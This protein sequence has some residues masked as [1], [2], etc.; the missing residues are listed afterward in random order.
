MEN[1]LTETSALYY[2]TERIPKTVLNSTGVQSW[3]HEDVLTREPISRFASAM[4]RDGAYLGAMPVNLFHF[5]KFDL[6]SITFNRIGYSVARTPLQ[7]ENDENFIL[8]CSKL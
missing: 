5:H 1:T 7:T 2:S 4:A 6:N 3:S 8:I